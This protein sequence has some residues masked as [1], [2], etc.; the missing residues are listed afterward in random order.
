MPF[1]SADLARERAAA[2]WNLAELFE[3]VVETCPERM[4]L[5]HG[6]GGIVRT[7]RE[8]DRRAN[9]LARHL[10]RSHAPGAKIALYAHNRPE[11]VEAL[12]AAM[13]ARL[14]TV[15][16]NYRYREDELAYL[17]DNSDSEVSTIG[18]ASDRSNRSVRPKV[19]A[20]LN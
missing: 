2:D 16:V 10:A 15:N 11:F 6:T 4:A 20:P 8:L 14:V 1:T 19:S 18:T 7:W 3:L 9:A 13:K 17:F 12:V 5:A